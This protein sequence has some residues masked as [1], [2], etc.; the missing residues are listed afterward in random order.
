VKS[1]NCGNGCARRGN[2][3]RNGENSE[4]EIVGEVSFVDDGFR[5]PAWQISKFV[6]LS[7][8]VWTK[9]PRLSLPEG[10]QPRT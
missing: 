10:F 5:K 4:R 1:L 7:A 2:G 9:L 8:T 6:V 3:N